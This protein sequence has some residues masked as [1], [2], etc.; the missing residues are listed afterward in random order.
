MQYDQL[1]IF[2]EK[3]PKIPSIIELFLE[4][5][6]CYQDVN[7]EVEVPPNKKNDKS[8]NERD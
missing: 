3:I 8:N 6:V 5:L 1:F 2:Q 7:E 4:G